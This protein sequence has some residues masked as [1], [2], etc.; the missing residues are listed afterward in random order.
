MEGVS[1]YRMDVYVFVKVWILISLV[2]NLDHIHMYVCYGAQ[3]WGQAGSADHDIEFLSCFSSGEKCVSVVISK[4]PST[5]LLCPCTVLYVCMYVC[6]YVCVCVC[7][8]VC[9]VYSLSSA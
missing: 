2:A 5:V 9:T 3:V 6:M 1:L 7:V 4:L 8:C